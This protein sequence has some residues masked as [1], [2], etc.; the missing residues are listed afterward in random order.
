MVG[1]LTRLLVGFHT[2][3]D[4]LLGMSA[5]VLAYAVRFEMEIIAA[6]KGQ[7]AFT[8]YLI[9]IHLSEYSFNWRFISKVP[10]AFVGIDHGLTTSSPFSSVT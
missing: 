1:R 2:V 5:F 10:T 3:T 6:P 4:A 8:Q 7:P 9:L